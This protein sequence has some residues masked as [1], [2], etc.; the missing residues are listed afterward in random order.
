MTLPVGILAP[1]LTL[2]LNFNLPRT[3]SPLSN[4]FYCMA[5]ILAYALTG[6]ITGAVFALCFNFIAKATGGIDAKYVS[7]V[8]EIAPAD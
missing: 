5:E 2:N 7:T 8:P 6:W 3:G 1:L 4:A